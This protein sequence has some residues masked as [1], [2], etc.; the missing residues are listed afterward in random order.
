MLINFK[1]SSVLS[2]KIV[3]SY[4][5][6]LGGNIIVRK[7]QQYVTIQL[8][9]DQ[10]CIVFGSID[11]TSLPDGDVLNLVTTSMNFN[12][13][14]ESE[15]VVDSSEGGCMFIVS[16]RRGGLFNIFSQILTLPPFRPPPPV[17]APKAQHQL[18]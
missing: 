16:R 5:A 3:L 4:S 2:N 17:V 7:L 1:S 15:K 9:E 14:E 13:F 8:S 10:F 11:S 12:A 6:L 18:G